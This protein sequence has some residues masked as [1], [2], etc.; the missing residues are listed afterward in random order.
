MVDSQKILKELSD[1]N[2]NLDVLVK[3]L[4]ATNKSSE[5][6]QEVVKKAAEEAAKRDESAIKRDEKAETP[7]KEEKPSKPVEPVKPV[8]PD[9]GEKKENPATEVIKE[10]Q[11][12][13]EE[14]QKD[15][16]GMFSKLLGSIKEGSD[17]SNQA[18]KQAGLQAVGATTDALLKGGGLKDAAKKGVSGG[19]SSLAGQAV[20]GLG[21]FA[22]K[23][24][25]EGISK[26]FS[27][28]VSTKDELKEKEEVEPV[29]KEGEEKKEK[30]KKRDIKADL[31]FLESLQKKKEGETEEG[32]DKKGLLSKL[33]EFFS[34]KKDKEELPTGIVESKTTLQDRVKEIFSSQKESTSSSKEVKETSVLSKI[35]DLAGGKGGSESGESSG[36]EGTGGLVS[37]VVKGAVLSKGGGGEGG[38]LANEGVKEAILSKGEALAESIAPKLGFSAD[39]IASGKEAL[40]DFKKE[41][42]KLQS[43]AGKSK[44]AEADKEEE[45]DEEESSSTDTSQSSSSSGQSSQATQGG[46]SPAEAGKSAAGGSDSITAQDLKDIKALLSAINTSLNSPLQIKDSK[47]FRPASNMLE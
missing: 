43:S 32:E 45:D 28:K 22:V 34:A 27:K 40:A 41:E 44:T 33:G 29:E 2:R 37:S 17:E 25:A 19:L 15:R 47:P 24:G 9:K 26:L 42:P 31:K 8:E 35:M 46:S 3:E 6:V 23:K 5:K 20:F 7:K 11:K 1:L 39:D 18:L 12:S 10:M 36:K 16:E 4:R 14:A 21:G 38:V 13:S 30:G